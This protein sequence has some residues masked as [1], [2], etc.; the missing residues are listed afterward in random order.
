MTLKDELFKVGTGI[1]RAILRATKGRVLGR[2]GGMPVIIL[3]STGRKSGKRR[4]TVLTAP[5][6][7]EGRMVLVASYGGDDRHPAWFLNV[8]DDPQVDVTI[9]GR[10]V[11]M[12]ARVASEQERAELWPRVVGAYPGYGEYQ[13]RSSRQIPL[14]VLEPTA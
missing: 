8:R 1:H 5:V 14:V 12:R 4:S 10:Q 7:G 6:C 9:A 3:T 13:R 2:L 11:S